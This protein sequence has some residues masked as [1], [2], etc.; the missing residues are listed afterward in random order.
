[1]RKCATLRI[2]LPCPWVVSGSINCIENCQQYWFID[3]SVAITD[4][5]LDSSGIQDANICRVI[6]NLSAKE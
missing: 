4:V 3:W 2:S 5:A 6:K 1:M